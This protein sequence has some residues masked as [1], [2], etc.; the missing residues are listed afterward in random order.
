M[1]PHVS[2]V[3]AARDMDILRAVLG[4]EKLTYVGASY[5][6]F[7]GAT[8]A[9]LFPSRVGR[10][11]LDGAMDPSLTAEELNRDQTAGFETA[12][13][14]FAAD[15]VERPDCPLGTTSPRT[16][17]PACAGSSRPW[18]APLSPPGTPAPSGRPSPP[19]G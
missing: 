4:D 16:P 19:P 10:L 15:C 13:R 9:E 6:T 1:L 12:F 17:G 8:Y 11:V 14:S 5:G 3:E 18:T 7:L 2:T